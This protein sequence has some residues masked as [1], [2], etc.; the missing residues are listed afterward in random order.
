MLTKKMVI[1]LQ[2][3]LFYIVWGIYAYF[4]N[5]GNRAPLSWTLHSLSPAEVVINTICFFVYSYD[6]QKTII[7]AAAPFFLDGTKLDCPC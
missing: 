6:L 3:C 1:Y 7:V 5:R 4:R 2:K